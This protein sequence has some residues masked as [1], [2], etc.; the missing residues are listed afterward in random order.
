MNKFKYIT[1]RDAIRNGN[2]EDADTSLYV[3]NTS[4]REIAGR[5]NLTV[6]SSNGQRMAVTIPRVA[7]PVNLTTMAMRADIMNCPDFR[8][9]YERGL[10]KIV[11]T[12]S[13]EDFYETDAGKR[14]HAQIYDVVEG[15]AEINSEPN[16]DMT[17]SEELAPENVGPFVRNIIHR[18]GRSDVTA[19]EL[20][21]EL[22]SRMDILTKEEYDFLVARLPDAQIK[23]WAATARS[24]C[25]E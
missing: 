4:P 12:E 13:A 17:G 18:A 3:L 6:S 9:I 11:D 25:F 1:F 19:D 7:G 5:I 10:I 16:A 22:E 21:S 20:I 2:G 23:E 8:R 24:A 14:L 15:D